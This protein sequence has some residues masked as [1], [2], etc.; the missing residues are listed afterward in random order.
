M[1]SNLKGEIYMC[2]RSI[3]C[4]FC[5]EYTSASP[6]VTGSC[7]H[8][9]VHYPDYT[10]TN[11]AVDCGT[12]QEREYDN[13]NYCFSFEPKELEFL[14]V[15][16]AHIDH[17]GRIPFLVK[18]G[19]S[20]PI[21]CTNDT[22]QI[23]DFSLRNSV[24]IVKSNA[25]KKGYEPLFV[26]EDVANAMLQVRGIPINSFVKIDDHIRAYFFTNGHLIGAATILVQIFYKISNQ[27]I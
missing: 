23:M 18:K 6:E 17:I 7:I 16:H 10:S 3:D 21:Y 20:G 9:I 27:L 15:T 19:F 14:L 12:F 24:H 22:K 26:S 5:V 8:C 11:F 1:K 13:L 2:D 25:G 4:P